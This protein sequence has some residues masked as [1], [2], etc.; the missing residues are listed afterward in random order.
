MTTTSEKFTPQLKRILQMAEIE[1]DRYQS[2]HVGI[3]HVSIAA[4][5]EGANI[6][7]EMMQQNGLTLDR[8]RALDFQPKPLT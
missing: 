8:I 1:A 7:F 2:G 3:E 5:Q 4:Y 6:A